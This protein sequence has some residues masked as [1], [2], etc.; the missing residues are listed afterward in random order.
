MVDQ[1]ADRQEKLEK[2]IEL[3]KKHAEEMRHGQILL[4]NLMQNIPQQVFVVSIQK[5]SA[6]FYNELASIEL[7]KEPEYIDRILESFPDFCDEAYYKDIEITLLNENDERF[8][9]ISS[10]PIKWGKVDAITLSISD[11]SNEKKQL[12]NLETHAYF[13][14]LTGLHNRHYGMR[15][16]KEWLDE[17]RAL[18]LTFI[19]L[20][21][22]KFINDEYGHEEGDRYVCT[23]A[24][25][26]TSHIND[27]VVC[28]VGG[29][30]YMVIKPD[31]TYDEMKTTM[32]KVSDIIDSNEYLDDKD[33]QYSISYGIVEVKE[34]NTLP[35]S[36]ILSTADERMYEHKRARK[37][38]RLVS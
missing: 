1:L 24:D 27:A 10:Y 7:E 29:D 34:D 35:Y 25:Y 8:L 2:E 28:R 30:E 20:D 14:A 9:R 19:D 36:V 15:V 18:A 4:S 37:K 21:S 12:K 6:L 11:I 22:L 13:D 3:S 31:I 17:K 26:L 38:E 16:L 33:F 32:D 23:V 5:G